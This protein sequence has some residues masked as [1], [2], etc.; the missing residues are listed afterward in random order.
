MIGRGDRENV[1]ACPSVGFCLEAASGNP[2]IQEARTVRYELFKENLAVDPSVEKV[3]QQKIDKV[4]ERLKRYHPDAADLSIHLE[5]IDKLK[6]H[7]CS[8]NLKAFKDSLHAKKSA[9]D[10]R[11]AIDR[12]FDALIRELDHYRSK[13]NKSLQPAE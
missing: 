9:P 8:L 13:I 2:P 10:L 6:S 1:P 4:E 12:C 7:E 3:I 5:Y 11:V